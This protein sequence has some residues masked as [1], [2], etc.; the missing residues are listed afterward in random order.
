MPNLSEQHTFCDPY[1]IDYLSLR[2]HSRAEKTFDLVAV[3]SDEGAKFYNTGSNEMDVRPTVFDSAQE[4]RDFAKEF[5]KGIQ[6][7]RD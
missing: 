7:Q 5:Y 1:Y 2:L 6:I 3:L 4:A